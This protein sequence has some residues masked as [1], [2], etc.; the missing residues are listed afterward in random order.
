MAIDIT[1]RYRRFRQWQREP[2]NYELKGEE[3]Q[4]CANCHHEYT[5]NY[6]PYC[7]Q[8]TGLG[9]VTWASVAK[10]ISIV[11]GMDNRSLLYSL[12]QLLLRPGYLIRDYINGERQASFPPVK[13]LM[14]VAIVYALIIHWTG[15]RRV[16]SDPEND[17]EFIREF[18]IWF[19]NNPGW[20]QLV[21]CSFL[22]LPTWLFFRY[23]PHNSHH[24][25]PMGFYI[26]VFMTTLVLMI[27][28]V[29]EPF[30]GDH[31]YWVI[32]FY[33]IVAYHQ[34]FG[35]GWWGTIWR[36]VL[37]G[38]EGF[39]L[40]I[41]LSMLVESIYGKPFVDNSILNWLFV[42]VVIIVNVVLVVVCYY[43]SRL[44]RRK[45][46]MQAEQN[47]LEQQH[48]ESPEEK[49]HEEMI[50]TE[51]LQFD[52]L[53]DELWLENEPQD[54]GVEEEFQLDFPQIEEPK[55]EESEDEDP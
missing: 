48:D 26:Q 53:Q 16:P 42:A 19:R 25:L 30:L 44:T 23:S 52:D 1:Q 17:F 51:K 29:A 8:K 20:G 7:S 35:Y 13:M 11:W 5:G 22:I 6:C 38:F 27:M 31:F 18:A 47:Q 37:T 40:L 32:L 39:F 55:E 50:L 49:Q 15:I 3:Q 36:T 46:D 10:G 41:T 24:T 9:K 2:F 4:Q 14:L 43:I 45:A 21:K 54:K 28:I 12:W 33:Y 34:L